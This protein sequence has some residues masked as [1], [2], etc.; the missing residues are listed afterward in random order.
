MKR[1]SSC[2]DIQKL[3]RRL[4]SEGWAFKQGGRHDRIK[5]QQGRGFLLVPG[6]PSDHRAFLNFSR[7]AKRLDAASRFSVIGSGP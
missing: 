4:L 2:K 3:V 1:Y 6:T 7:A 5:P